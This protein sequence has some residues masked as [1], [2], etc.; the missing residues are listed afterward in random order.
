MSPWLGMVYHWALD[1]DCRHYWSRHAFVELHWWSHTSFERIYEIYN[2]C[3]N[4]IIQ[5][6]TCMYT[7]WRHLWARQV[8]EDGP[9]HFVLTDWANVSISRDTRS[10]LALSFFLSFFSLFLWS[11]KKENSWYRCKWQEWNGEWPNQASTAK[12]KNEAQ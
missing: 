3:H 6:S 9:F 1:S 10:S 2:S 8:Y 12:L 4:T 5:I 7:Q 11:D